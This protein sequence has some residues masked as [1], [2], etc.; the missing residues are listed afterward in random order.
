[1]QEP[2]I[3]GGHIISQQKSELKFESNSSQTFGSE[4]LV[5]LFPKYEILSETRVHDGGHNF[6]L[7]TVI[8]SGLF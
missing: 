1:M 5:L 4:S 8:S 2:E 3:C 6:S 7:A